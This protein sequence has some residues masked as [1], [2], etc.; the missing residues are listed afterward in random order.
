M[1]CLVILS[2]AYER[3]LRLAAVRH[4]GQTRRGDLTPYIT[5]PV[6]VAR[7]VECVG[8]DEATVVAALLHDLL[9]DTPTTIDELRAQFGD[10][11]ADTVAGCSEGKIDANG[12]VRSWEERKRDHLLRLGLA[13]PAV[14]GVVLADKLHNLSCLR[15]SLA[16]GRQ[17]WDEF[18]ASRDRVLWYFAAIIECCRD[19]DPKISCLSRLCH[20]ELK[21]VGTDDSKNSDSGTAMT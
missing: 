18:H 17:I 6:A 3:A 11:V 19:D 20:D 5:H 13:T 8:F 10:Q 15:L 14:K 7:I 16:S 21:F 4:H 9:E 2:D 12:Q 1:S